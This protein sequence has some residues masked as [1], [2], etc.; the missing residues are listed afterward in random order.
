[1][2]RWWW[3][4]NI[5]SVMAIK[6]SQI[7][8]EDL[9]TFI[10]KQISRATIEDLVNIRMDTPKRGETL[11]LVGSPPVWANNPPPEQIYL[12]EDGLQIVIGSPPTKEMLAVDN[13]VLRTNTRNRLMMP[14]SGKSNASVVFASGAPGF[15]F[16]QVDADADEMVYRFFASGG[17]L[18]FD[19]RNDRNTK[20]QNWLFVKRNGMT[21][22]QI[23]LQGSKVTVNG[24]EIA[25]EDDIAALLARIEALE[26]V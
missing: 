25:T 19:I 5:N 6:I 1:M 21:I 17:D 14:V 20:S 11:T 23:D 22:E 12:T 9:R 15:I 26:N 10:E 8:K 4:V 7:D 13:T 3:K 16:N 24:K 2:L 18:A